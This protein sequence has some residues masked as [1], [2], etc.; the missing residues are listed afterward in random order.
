ME[1]ACAWDR[2]LKGALGAALKRCRTPRRSIGVPAR[3]RSQ[4][5]FHVS[6]VPHANRPKI[7]TRRPTQWL[8]GGRVAANHHTRGPPMRGGA[9]SHAD[10]RESRAPRIDTG[11]LYAV[12]QDTVRIAQKLVSDQRL[13]VIPRSSITQI[14]RPNGRGPGH[15]AVGAG[16]G[17]KAGGHMG[18]LVGSSLTTTM[19]G[20]SASRAVLLR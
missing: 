17:F 2:A 5:H 7:I 3:L 15:G 8:G 9:G 4:I 16:I 20:A 12:E 13:L 19:R 11:D 1:N 18:G 14:W 6:Q 10:C